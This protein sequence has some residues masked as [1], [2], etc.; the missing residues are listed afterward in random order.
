MI[1]TPGLTLPLRLLATLVTRSTHQG[2]KAMNHST[3]TSPAGFAVVARPKRHLRAVMGS[4]YTGFVRRRR[5]RRAIR[6]LRSLD[7]HLL[8]DMGLHRGMIVDVVINGDPRRARHRAVAPRAAASP[9][10]TS[11]ATVV[12]ADPIDAWAR[13]AMAGNGF[14]G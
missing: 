10:P 14:G 9:N 4:W 1:F 12:A 6:E 2:A 3:M 7:A 13:R 8:R 11:T 5:Q